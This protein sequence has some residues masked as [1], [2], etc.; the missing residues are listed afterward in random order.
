MEIITMKTAIT[1]A[2]SRFLRALVLAIALSGAAFTASASVFVSVNFAPPPLPVY[3]QPICPGPEYIWVPGY[4]A[5]GPDGYYWVPGTWVLAPYVGALWTPGYWGWDGVVFVWHPGYWGP[6]VGFYGGIDYGFGYFGVGYVGGYWNH[7]AFFYNTA[8]NNVNLTVIHN[9]YRSSVAQNTGFSRVSFNGG[10]GGTTARPTAQD[11]LAE[12]DQ[13]RAATPLQVQHER[14]ASTNRALLASVNHGTPRLAATPRAAAFGLHAGTGT[15]SALR[16]P[17]TA[18]S[19]TGR[20]LRAQSNPPHVATTHP[21]REF[22]AQ[23]NVPH[24]SPPPVNRD[25]HTEHA[26]PY[27]SVRPPQVQ[28]F[29]GPERHAQTSPQF[30]SRPAPERRAFN[31]PRM[32]SMPAPERRAFNAPRMESRP[33]PERHAFNAPRMESMP[34]PQFHAQ[35]APRMQS[36]PAPERRA[37]GGPRP[38]GPAHEGRGENRHHEEGPGR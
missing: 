34:A 36:L 30:Q 10:A 27:A 8:V 33:A 25:W 9:T 20:E 17:L 14:L 21:S 24:G 38:Q 31:A 7:G 35:N 23:A 13:H 26:A 18:G 4:W 29:P 12:R 5:Y 16:A 19:P 15:T 11:R 2:R 22:R 1:F 37:E 3:V 28:R 6:H 32:E